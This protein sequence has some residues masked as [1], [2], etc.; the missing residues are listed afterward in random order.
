MKINLKITLTATILAMSSLASCSNGT[1]D[2]VI[3]YTNDV[4][5]AI[6]K[7]I[8]YDGLKAVQNE[9]NASGK[10]TLLVDCGD[11]IQGGPVGLLSKGEHLVNI[12]N[13]MNYDLAIPGNHEFDYSADTFVTLSKKAKYKYISTNFLY[14]KDNTTVFD[15]YKI[16]EKAG[17]KIGFVGICTPETP[18]TTSPKNFEDDKGNKKYTFLEGQDP[19]VFYSNVQN[20][21]NKI[22]KYN[23]DY[24]VALAHI[25]DGQT[26]YTSEKLVNNVSGLDVCLDGHSHSTVVSNIVKDKDGKD[27]IISQTGTELNN[28]GQLTITREGK[29]STSLIKKEDCNKK[30]EHIHSFITDINNKIKEK[31]SEKIGHTNYK[32]TIN[33]ISTG[34]R[35]IRQRETNMGDLVAD[36]FKEYGKCDV[37]VTNAGGVRADINVGDIT[38]GDAM[39]V[40]PFGNNFVSVKTSGLSLKNYIE[41]GAKNSPKE[42]PTLVIPSGITYTIDTSIESTVELTPEGTFSKVGGAYRTK[43]IK[44]NGEDLDEN[45]IYS[46]AGTNYNLLFS[47]DAKAIF[48]DAEI[49]NYGDEVEYQVFAHYIKETLKGEIPERYSNPLGQGRINII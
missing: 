42:D 20:T 8:G 2:L 26:I 28:I 29:I 17:R 7:N 18:K 15:A 16:I 46:V 34:K 11:H 24:I 45:K 40:N 14:A 4:H 23:V 32:L 25:G 31:T 22:K 49:V 19:S 30:D 41:F 44:I 33:D 12:M 5:C 6:D 37:G 10:E 48:K 27:V 35:A 9:I 13:E 3:L 47:T 39:T 1:K 38:F 21:I 43:D 36:A